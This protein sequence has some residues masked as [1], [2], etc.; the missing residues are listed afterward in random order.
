[1]HHGMTMDRAKDPSPFAWIFGGA[2]ALVGLAA[3]A[4]AIRKGNQAQMEDV[5]ARPE[6]RRPA[7]TVGADSEEM[8][9]GHP[10]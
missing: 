7:E 8:L 6:P 9:G 5:W 10:S 4:S 1:M 2:L 3:A